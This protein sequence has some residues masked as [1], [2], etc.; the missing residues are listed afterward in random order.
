MAS[1]AATCN[2]ALCGIHSAVG[3]DAAVIRFQD[4]TVRVI[5]AV[6]TEIS[7]DRLART[8]GAGGLRRASIASN[9]S[10]DRIRTSRSGCSLWNRLTA[11]GKGLVWTRV[12]DPVFDG[13]IPGGYFEVAQRVG[14]ATD[15]DLPARNRFSCRKWARAAILLPVDRGEVFNACRAGSKNLSRIWVDAAV[16]NC[17]GS[18][19]RI[20]I[21]GIPILEVTDVD[22][23][24]HDGLASRER[25]GLTL[26]TGP[27]Q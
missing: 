3:D 8:K 9:Q 15:G 2:F 11:S 14:V 5:L 7:S 21:A 12:Y 17:S 10:V 23:V 1:S 25:A 26:R 16:G 20:E 6:H 4:E 18:G 19:C 27:S 22:L 24:S 13:S